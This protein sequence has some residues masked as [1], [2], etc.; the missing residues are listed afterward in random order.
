VLQH[1]E[2]V[3]R[4]ALLQVALLLER[5][6]RL[7]KARAV[8]ELDLAEDQARIGL[9]DGRHIRVNSLVLLVVIVVVFFDYLLGFFVV[10]LLLKALFSRRQ[11][12]FAVLERA[13]RIGAG[14]LA[15]RLQLVHTSSK[16][17]A[18]LLNALRLVAR[19]WRGGRLLLFTSR[20]RARV[21]ASILIIL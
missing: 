8:V 21:L 14:G 6:A 4:I 2:L 7:A 16:L 1:L 13:G 11:Q 3:D 19:G 10:L 18:Q 17:R 15:L 9:G 12:L 5:R 20:S